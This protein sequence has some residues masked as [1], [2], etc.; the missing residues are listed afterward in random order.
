MSGRAALGCLSSMGVGAVIALFALNRACDNINADWAAKKADEAAQQRADGEAAARA[1][2]EYRRQEQIKEQQEAEAKAAARR[3]ALDT[4]IKQCDRTRG[5][6]ARKA[7]QVCASA[8]WWRAPRG[9]VAARLIP[10]RPM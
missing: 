2:N 6:G 10:K 4:L 9:S 7:E 8:P 5:M 3:Q 1:D